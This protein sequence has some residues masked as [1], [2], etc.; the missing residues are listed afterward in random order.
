[1]CEV[2]TRVDV[3]EQD[4]TLNDTVYSGWF[5]KNIGETPVSIN[6]IPVEPGDYIDMTSI[7][8]RWMSPIQIVVGT[9]KLVIMRLLYTKKQ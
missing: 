6:K 4:T 3:I 8:A 2:T 5:A 7:T 1:M 9:G